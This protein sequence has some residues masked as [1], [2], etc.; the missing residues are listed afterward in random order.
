MPLVTDRYEFHKSKNSLVANSSFVYM[1][2]TM[3]HYDIS[4]LGEYLGEREQKEPD[5]EQKL[6]ESINQQIFKDF[7]AKTTTSHS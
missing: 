5:Y 2:K 6:F 3:K 7:D 4:L 1:L